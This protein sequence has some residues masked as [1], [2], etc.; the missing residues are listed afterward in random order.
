MAVYSGF[1]MLSNDP[2]R[3]FAFGVTIEDTQS[4]CW[5]FS[6]SFIVVS[7]PFNFIELK[8]NTVPMTNFYYYDSSQRADWPLLAGWSV[9]YHNK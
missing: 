2:R 8:K 6:R 3:R 1:H 4:R 7:T 9:R 5:Y